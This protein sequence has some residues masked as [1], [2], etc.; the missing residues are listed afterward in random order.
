MNKKR[1]IQ[2]FLA[3]SASFRHYSYL[4]D[5]SAHCITIIIRK[6][7][8]SKVRATAAKSQSLH[9]DQPETLS[10]CVSLSRLV[11]CNLCHVQIDQSL[12]ATMIMQLADEQVKTIIEKTPRPLD[13]PACSIAVA[14]LLYASQP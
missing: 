4:S 14:R 13:R 5:F 1:Y 6:V 10:L 3:I 2:V 9:R 8:I 12:R 11:F 7:I